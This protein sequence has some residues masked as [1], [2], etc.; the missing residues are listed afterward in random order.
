M[1]ADRMHAAGP[2]IRG[3]GVGLA[4]LYERLDQALQF[5]RAELRAIERRERDAEIDALVL[6]CTPWRV[7]PWGVL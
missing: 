2:G 7:P 5:Y 1:S 4:G 3:P 6:A